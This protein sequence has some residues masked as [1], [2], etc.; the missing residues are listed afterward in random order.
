M[1]GGGWD[2]QQMEQRKLS[3]KHEEM[4]MELLSTEYNLDYSSVMK[5]IAY[6]CIIDTLDNGGNFHP[7]GLLGYLCFRKE[8]I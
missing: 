4:V 2:R 1:G 3:L 5:N 8:A 7:N 6:I